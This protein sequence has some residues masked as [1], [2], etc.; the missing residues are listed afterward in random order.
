[1]KVKELLNVTF[2]ESPPPTKL[3]PL[4]DYNVGEEEEAI[5]KNTKIVNTNNEEDESIEVNKI[6]NIKES[7][8]HPL[9]QVIGNLNQRT[10]RSQAKIIMLKKFGLEDSKPIKT[11][12][13]T[14]IKLTKDDEADSVDN[15]K[16]RENPKTTHLEV[17]KHIFRY[18]RGTSHL[19]L[20]YQKGTRIETVVYADSDH[21]SNYVDCKS[22]S[23]VCT[24]LGCCL[25]SWFTKKH[26]AL[27]VSTNEAEYVFA[28]KACQQ[29]LWMKQALIDYG[30]RLDDVLIMCDNKGAID[31]REKLELISELVKYQDHRA[32]ILKYQAEQSKP[33]SKKEQNEFYMSVLRSHVKH[34]IIDWEIHSEGKRE[35][36]KIIRLGGH[37]AVYQLF[38]D[39]LKQFD[40]EGLHQLWTLV[41]EIFSIRQATKDKE[42]EL[43][44][45][46]KRLFEPDFE[47]QL[48]T[49]N[50]AF[51][52]D[53]LD[54]KLYDT[55]GVH[56]VSTKDQEIFML[57]ER[58]CPLRK[59]LAIVMIR[60]K[61]QVEQ[62]SQMANDLILKIHNI[63]NS[64]R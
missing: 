41:K 39:M 16:Y 8:N 62:Y 46:L 43:W 47:D 11:P 34:P 58:D 12:M 35:Y 22:T 26:T 42:K 53:P 14:G 48:W 49:H 28:G 61:L 21:A 37:T 3:S 52:H 15:S 2:D 10:L 36:W 6:V 50:Q 13:S 31:L 9:D 57:V 23:G 19:G 17:V 38:V 63:A 29:A 51:M 45:E 7:K 30:I 24:F 59:G 5:R 60:N 54:W 55:C 25:T 40:R 20:W 56:H 32:K 33:L 4:V 44:V 18:I 1:M 27:A 64:P